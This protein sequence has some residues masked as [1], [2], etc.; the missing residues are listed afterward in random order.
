MRS[1]KDTVQD[2][3]DLKICVSYLCVQSY[4]FE[5]CDFLLKVALRVLKYVNWLHE[6]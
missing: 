1:V 4:D 5:E 6:L 2:T 3:L